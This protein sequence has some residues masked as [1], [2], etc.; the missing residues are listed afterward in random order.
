[1]L[2]FFKLF[3]DDSKDFADFISVGRLLAALQDS[4]DEG[5]S[6]SRTKQRRGTLLRD[7]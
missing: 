1:M 7:R 6:C 5:L 2:L 4:H 3:L